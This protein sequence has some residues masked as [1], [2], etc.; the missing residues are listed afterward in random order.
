MEEQCI[1]PST[2]RSEQKRATG[3]LS[4][5]V[6]VHKGIICL[7]ARYSALWRFRGVENLRQVVGGELALAA[8]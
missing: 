3:R 8:G 1:D 2:S 7:A 6:S 5:A 4:E